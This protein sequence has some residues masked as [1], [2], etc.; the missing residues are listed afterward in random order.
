MNWII[1]ILGG[2]TSDDLKTIKIELEAKRIQDLEIARQ[3][4]FREG[5]MVY[6][7][8]DGYSL[9]MY[10]L[11]VH[12]VRLG[13]RGDIVLELKRNKEDRGNT[14]DILAKFA[15]YD[16]PVKCALCGVKQN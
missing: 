14:L 15:S 9:N 5:D 10:P 11:Y 12:K 3:K 1:K 8:E 7:H 16:K 6:N 4:I 13:L 2:Y